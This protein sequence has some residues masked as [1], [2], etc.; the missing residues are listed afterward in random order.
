[1]IED[2]LFAIIDDV[3]RPIG[4]TSDDGEEFRDPPLDVL[5]YPS[6]AGPAP[7]GALAGP[8]LER[9]GGGPPAD[10]RRL[11]DRRL[12]PVRSAGWRW[13]PTAVSAPGRAGVGWSS[14]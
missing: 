12:P 10:R 9:G 8:G 1:M 13:R 2:E 14:A 7:L 6:P 3:L 11:L 5:R 4:A